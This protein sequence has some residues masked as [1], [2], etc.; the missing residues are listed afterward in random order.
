MVDDLNL[1]EKESATL[2]T[3]FLRL[4]WNTA[5][6]CGN[7]QIDEQHQNLFKL[8]N[9]LLTAMIAPQE[10]AVCHQYIEALISDIS[11]HFKTEEQLIEEAGYPH[12]EEH[13][14]IH[15]KLTNDALKIARHHKTGRLKIAEVFHFLAMEVVSQHMLNEDRKFFAYFQDSRKQK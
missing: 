2:Q 13:R 10:K 9:M 1:E 7:L 4:E 12:T 15:K 6:E 3:G 5:Y 11:K 14:Q 8:A